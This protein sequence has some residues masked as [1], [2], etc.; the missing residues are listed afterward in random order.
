MPSLNFHAYGWT[1]IRPH[2]QR[3][4]SRVNFHAYGWKSIVEDPRAPGV[5]LSS[6][7]AS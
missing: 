6:P 3:P 2:A 1:F 7:A 5:R 4:R